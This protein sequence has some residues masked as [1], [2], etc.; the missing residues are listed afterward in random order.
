MRRITDISQ[1]SGQRLARSPHAGEWPFSF[2]AIY[3]KNINAFALPGGPV[4]IN[5][6]TIVAADNEAQL[7][8]VMAHEMSHIVL[9][10]GTHQA[11][12]APAHPTPGMLAGATLGNGILGRLGGSALDSAR[13]RCC[14]NTRAMPKRRPTTMARR[15]WRT[16]VQSGRDG[17]ILRETGTQGSEGRIA[18]FLSDHPTPGNRVKAVEEEIQYLPKKNYRDN[19]TGQFQGIQTVVQRLKPPKNYKPPAQNQ[20]PPPGA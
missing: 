13:T 10:H 11:S 1:Q 19:I 17:S 14:C 20:N 18:Q 3:D 16:S 7:A 8:G 2:A 9:R 6:A 15:S 12:K 4:F 5:T